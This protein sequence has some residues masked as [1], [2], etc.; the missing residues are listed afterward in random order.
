MNSQILLA[1]CSVLCSK[2]I[3]TPKHSQKRPQGIGH[4]KICLPGEN[5]EASPLMWIYNPPHEALK[6][7]N[8]IC[9]IED[10]KKP[11]VARTDKV[12]S[13][14]HACDPGIADVG[15]VQECE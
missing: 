12:E 9:N 7:K 2:N 15:A 4:E 11:V 8:N 10:G 13:L 5:D 1:M 3:L 6:L 14:V